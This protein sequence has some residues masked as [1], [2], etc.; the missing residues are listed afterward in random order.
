MD[1]L[2]KLDG[3]AAYD[4]KAT[5][6]ALQDVVLACCPLRELLKQHFIHINEASDSD[7]QSSMPRSDREPGAPRTSSD[8]RPRSSPLG[9]IGSLGNS[10]LKRLSNLV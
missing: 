7:I 6:R 5:G 9:S 3:S 4:T 10:S 2:F 8:I 1:S